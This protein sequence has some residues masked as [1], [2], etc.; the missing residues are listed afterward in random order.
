MAKRSE[1][2]INSTLDVLSSL[3]PEDCLKGN[4]FGFIFSHFITALCFLLVTPAH[5]WCLW[6]HFC[7]KRKIKVTQF[8]FLN[9]IIM[10]LIFCMECGIELLSMVFVKNYMMWN[11]LYF[12]FGLSWVG[13]PLLQTCICI[14][15]YLAVLHPVTFL[16]YKGIKYRIAATV[17]AW[18]M[19]SAYGVNLANA[20]IFPD[21]IYTFVFIIALSVVSFCCVSVLCALKH[22]GPGDTHISKRT[23]RDGGNQQKRNAFKTIFSALLLIL[24]TYLPQTILIFFNGTGVDQ[25]LFVC[26]VVPFINSV[27]VFGV[28]IT[29]LL[30]LYKESHQQ[31][32][33]H[34]KEIKVT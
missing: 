14:E 24:F 18:L 19:A 10:E 15:R 12:F 33:K 28:I 3:M 23:G 29:P 16:R 34:Q 7:T 30:K 32:L 27:N 22:P 9:N 11:V 21:Y 4:Y 1:Q 31:C 26:S 5:L 13:R 20:M 2:F 17:A 8:F 25:I 6:V